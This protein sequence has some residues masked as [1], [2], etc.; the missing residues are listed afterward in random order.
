MGRV[1]RCGLP[2]GRRGPGL[3]SSKVSVT[4]TRCGLDV[5]GVSCVSA[6]YPVTS[7]K[8]LS[9]KA[10]IK[11]ERSLSVSGIAES[12]GNECLSQSWLGHA[13]Q[14]QTHG[15]RRAILSDIMVQV[16][17]GETRNVAR[18]GLEQQTSQ[19]ANRQPQQEP[20]R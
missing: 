4:P 15:L 5:L 9:R 10:A 11:N 18:R 6:P 20:T 1:F 7:R 12:G 19:P 2:S 13:R 3:T 17:A 14:A 8:W 16:G